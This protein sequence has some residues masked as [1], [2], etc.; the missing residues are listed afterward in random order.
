MIEACTA[1]TP[2]GKFVMYREFSLAQ[3][4]VVMEVPTL[5]ID[6]QDLPVLLG[7]SNASASRFV[8]LLEEMRRLGAG[9]LW[10]VRHDELEE[11]HYVARMVCSSYACTCG[12]VQSSG[13]FDR[14]VMVLL[15]L[16]LV[17]FVPLLHLH[18]VYLLPK[19]LDVADK[20]VWSVGPRPLV[21]AVSL[22]AS[23]SAAYRATKLLWKDAR[24]G[25]TGQSALA[26]DS[27][28][29][30]REDSEPE[31]LRKRIFE[32]QRWAAGDPTLASALNGKAAAVVDEVERGE[33]AAK[34]SSCWRFGSEI[35]I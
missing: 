16:I 11:I 29:K 1:L 8:M 4:F 15:R 31:K 28:A 20:K 26:W 2:E 9:Q 3:G 10:R 30:K 34:P 32:L 21:E 12:C 19:A 33:A 24:L 7:K 25:V 35:Y 27:P 14:H 23:W 18:P 17:A 22:E 5:E 6:E 13:R